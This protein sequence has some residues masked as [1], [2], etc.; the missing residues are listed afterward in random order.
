MSS[1]NP[2]DQ[3]VT[4]AVNAIVT[5][6]NVGNKEECIRRAEILLASPLLAHLQF[7]ILVVLASATKDVKRANAYCVEAESLWLELPEWH[8]QR[9]DLE[10]SRVLE[11]LRGILDGLK[12]SLEQ[13]A[14]NRPDYPA[15][16][17]Q[18]KGLTLVAVEP[19]DPIADAMDTHMIDEE[20]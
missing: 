17:D 19:S 16:M 6:Y 18:M 20:N 4:D 2:T 7:H 14:K 5:L 10:I 13:E 9:G 1:S 8:S 11:E 3:S 15:C 12:L